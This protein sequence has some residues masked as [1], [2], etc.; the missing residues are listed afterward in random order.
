MH[1]VGD[2][3]YIISNK[4]RNVVPV[5][6]V[7]QIVRRTIEGEQVSFKVSLPGKNAQESVDL[8][9][10]DGTSYKSLSD[11]RR[12]LY[13]QATSAINQLLETAAE[14]SKVHFGVD[15]SIPVS[16]EPIPQD[17]T[18]DPN[19]QFDA[20]IQHEPKPLESLS[21]PAGSLLDFTS[22]NVTGEVKVQMPDG[23][24]ASVQMPEM[25]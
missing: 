6:V 11:A 3:L 16:S 10:I 23:S 15:P 24:Y 18:A 17:Q 19:P 9:S 1:S 12:F 5:R 7:E 13:E 21:N 22:A 25:Q 2:V 20:E 4:K 8:H 14:V